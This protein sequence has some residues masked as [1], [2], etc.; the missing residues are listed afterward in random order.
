MNE[1][2]GGGV[3]G[4]RQEGEE[5]N[6]S[7]PRSLRRH[8]WDNSQYNS[9]ILIFTCHQTDTSGKKLREATPR[10][11]KHDTS[12]IPLMEDVQARQNHN[13]V[14]KLSELKM[15]PS[16]F[17]LQNQNGLEGGSKHGRGVAGLENTQG[18]AASRTDCKSFD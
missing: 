14:G 12:W 6:N 1:R 13:S 11:G 3:G 9:Q 2:G 15:I 16:V 8:M 5:M 4:G 18:R 7:L 10:Q 17:L